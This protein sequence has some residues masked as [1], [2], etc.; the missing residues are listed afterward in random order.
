MTAWLAT[1]RAAHEAAG[2]DPWPEP[3]GVLL[4][5]ARRLFLGGLTAPQAGARTA[6]RW[7]LTRPERAAPSRPP[8]A[9]M[10]GNLRVIHSQN[11]HAGEDPTCA[12]SAHSR[13]LVLDPAW[14]GGRS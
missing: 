6:A 8:E 14:P 1:W 4:R 10:P 7:P 3:R 12:G 9:R 2:G 13:A 5:E 11:P